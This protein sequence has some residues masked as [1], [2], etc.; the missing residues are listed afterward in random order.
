MFGCP[1]L[2]SRF[3][4]FLLVLDASFKFNPFIIRPVLH[5]DDYLASRLYLTAMHVILVADFRGFGE[6][7]IAYSYIL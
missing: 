3:A 2:I 5:F 4:E 7:V 1:F 6:I